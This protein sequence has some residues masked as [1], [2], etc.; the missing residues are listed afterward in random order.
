MHSLSTAN[1]HEFEIVPSV[2]PSR[3]GDGIDHDKY[4]W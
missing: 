2:A 1:A 3:L 4:S